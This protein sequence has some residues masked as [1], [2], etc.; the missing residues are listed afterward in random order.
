[1]KGKSE[2]PTSQEESLERELKK[3]KE[4]L[5]DQALVIDVLKKNRC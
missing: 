1:V 5:G 3:S 4:L 2:R